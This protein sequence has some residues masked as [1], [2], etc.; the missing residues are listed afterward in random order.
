MQCCDSVLI[1][2]LILLFMIIMQA[3]IIPKHV[4]DLL[5]Q[6]VST[7]FTILCVSLTPTLSLILKYMRIKGKDELI[8]VLHSA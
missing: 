2:F 1:V 4:I 7:F 6:H 3:S 5:V 8:N